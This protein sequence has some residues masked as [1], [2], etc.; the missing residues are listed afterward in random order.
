MRVLQEERMKKKKENGSN[1]MK[2]K[3]KTGIRDGK[4]EK[5]G[6]RELRKKGEWDYVRE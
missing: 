5:M 4:I 1:K 2:E 3:G 6:V